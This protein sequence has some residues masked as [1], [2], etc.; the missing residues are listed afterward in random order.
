MVS[1]RYAMQRPRRPRRASTLAAA[2]ALAIGLLGTA[3]AAQPGATGDGMA[4]TG[5][6]VQGGGT[7]LLSYEMDFREL[8]ALYPLQLRGV[9]ARNGVAFS[10]RADRVVTGGQLRLLYSYSP[11][12]IPALSQI[13]V[14]VNEEVAASLPTPK[15]DAG[16]PLEAVIDIPGRLITDFNRLNIQLIG[17]YTLEC[18]DPMHT[19]L[20][21][22]VSNQ[23]QLTVHTQ[24]IALRNDLALLPLPFFDRRDVRRLE[25][26]FVF[27]GAPSNEV[28]EAAGVV[29]SWFGALAEYRGASFPVRQGGAPGQGNAV[30]FSLGGARAGAA[31]NG[32]TVS[33][34]TNPNDPYGKLLVISGRNADEL[35]AA[36]QALA[37][38]NT[39]LSG[40]TATITRLDEVL[41]RKPYDAP[42]WLRSDR[43]VEFGEL[44]PVDGMTVA[45]YT[46]DLVRVPLRLPPDL[47]AWREKGI[48][49]DLKY[50]YSPPFEPDRSALNIAIGE[51]FVRAIPLL[52]RDGTKLQDGEVRRFI[53]RLM[54]DG[55][56]EGAEKLHLPLHMLPPQS[57]LQL[58]FQYATPGSDCLVTP[59]DNVR[60]SILPESTI[61]ISG[62]KHFIAMPDLAAFGNAGF[63]FTRMADLSESAIVM[64][65]NAGEA[66][67][68]A[69]LTLMGRFGA[70]TGY[71]AT[72]ARVIQAQSVDQVAARDL[73]VLASGGNQ[74]LLETWRSA[75]GYARDGD[76]RSFSL[77]DLVYRTVPWL[78]PDQ[79]N[80]REAGRL[81]LAVRS[82]ATD[83]VLSGFESPL[84]KGRSVVAISSN[85]P[86]GL[87]AASALLADAQSDMLSRI[88]GSLVVLRG[89]QVDS[90]AAEQTYYVGKL[91]P[92][93]YVRWYLS[94]RPLLLVGMGLLAAAVL[95]VLLYLALRA[96]ARRRLALTPSVRKDSGS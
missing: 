7:D 14:M 76:E 45:G 85:A 44:A 65:E 8:G 83:A 89:E 41:P 71:P 42:N 21:A 48:P 32:P 62:L 96:R 40:D 22:N 49:I 17:H 3:Q 16:K 51:Q 58:H 75:A 50:R 68:S 35:K 24:P 55:M 72:G 95:A 92:I 15:E 36:A 84:A 38:G 33:V 74:P 19:S 11:A 69:F 56:A 28:L 91:D 47:F 10:V 57:Q 52:P 87:Q 54:P 46:P 39:A 43:P 94:T 78:A 20:W 23:S 64:P 80:R 88:Q 90:L 53:A 18:E 79:Y 73:L 37:L 77:S 2:C 70:V 12:L 29:S 9:D 63:P 30:V 27:D 86:Q 93:T 1:S 61:D 25:L 13:N 26:P 82:N 59:P 6:P 81:Q 31:A 60:S 34:R 4:R 66:D 67:I 5:G